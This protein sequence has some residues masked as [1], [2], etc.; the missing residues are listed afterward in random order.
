MMINVQLYHATK[1]ISLHL[2]LTSIKIV[3]K[4]SFD[5]EKS[6]S[7][8]EINQNKSISSEMGEEEKLN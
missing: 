1:Q 2:R 3:L 5:F 7:T 6:K 4:L 8:K